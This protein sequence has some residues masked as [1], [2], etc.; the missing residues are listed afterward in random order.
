[1]KVLLVEDDIVLAQTI[2]TNLACES[3]VVE[4]AENGAD[5]SFLARSFDYDAIVLDNS[6]PKKDG[7]TVCKEVRSSGKMTPIIFLTVDDTLETK[8]N[9]FDMGAD[10]YIQKPFSLR[11]LSVRLKA[12]ARRPSSIKNHILKVDD[13][14]L[15]TEKHTITRSGVRIHVT[16]KEFSLL[17]FFL[18]NVGVVLSRALLMEHVWT[19]DSN[20]FSNT[21]EAHIRNLRKKLNA[22]KRQNLIA[23]IPGR[24]YVI[25]TPENIK[26]SKPRIF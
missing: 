3:H 5:G 17:E 7:L 21:V 10:D 11:E 19:A 1:M 16:R 25:D 20:P 23:N 15:D 14:E 26:E 9:A 12:V 6:L 13:L 22:G 18:R 24:G 4:I 8:L 2:K